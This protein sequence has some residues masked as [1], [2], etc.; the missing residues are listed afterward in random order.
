MKLRNE[1]LRYINALRAVTGANA[2]DCWYDS[3]GITFL[4]SADQMRLAIGRKGNSIRTLREKMGKNIEL[5]EYAEKPEDF[6]K[7]AF[8]KIKIENVELAK[9]ENKKT[10]SICMDSENRRKL[11]QNLNRLRRVRETMKR[12]YGIGELKIRP[13]GFAYGKR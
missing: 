3:S 11:L 7:K 5:L 10:I 8:C 9:D 12:D 2:K 4:L 1:E 13:G 6:V